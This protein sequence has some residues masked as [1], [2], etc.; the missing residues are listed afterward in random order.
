MPVVSRDGLSLYGLA[1]TF[2]LLPKNT[3][4][5]ADDKLGHS[6]IHFRDQRMVF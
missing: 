2:E 1:W 3:Q 6:P 4:R 5:P